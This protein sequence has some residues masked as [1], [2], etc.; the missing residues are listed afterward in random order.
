MNCRIEE[1]DTFGRKLH[2][3]IP[4]ADF[5]ERIDAKLRK[6]STTAEIKGFR[7]GKAPLE[8][9]KRYY[10]AEVKADVVNTLLYESYEEVTKQHDFFVLSNPSFEDIEIDTDKGIHYTA[11]IEVLP[12]LQLNTYEDITIEKPICEIT[13]KDID[14]MVERVRMN[15][16]TWQVK[17]GPACVGDKVTINV[18]IVETDKKPIKVFDDKSY[19]LGSKLMSERL[20]RQIENMRAGEKKE[21]SLR[22]K[23]DQKTVDTADSD[24]TAMRYEVSL[25]SV[26]TAVLPELD[27]DFFKACNIE[28]G[29]VDALRSSLREGMEWELKRK[30]SQLRRT[31]VENAMLTHANI[32]AP[33]AMMKE[34]IEKMKKILAKDGKNYVNEDISDE[35]FEKTAERKVC[36]DIL[37]IYI[38]EKNFFK[39]DRSAREAKINELVEGYKDPERMKNYYHG[40]VEAY[41]KVESMVLED[42]IIDYVIEKANISEKVYPFYE[43]MDMEKT[44]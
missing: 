22:E 19:I 16:A 35:L 39:I 12:D 6:L 14:T 30:L 10:G 31:N 9:I 28:E 15:H 8:I 26:A 43:L 41:R 33:P 36:L 38:N 34:Q 40:S 37:F 17:D 24:K 27:D 2:I 18:N 44:Q 13:E 1:I 3:D 42:K 29:G 25:K 11:Y 5:N 32:K 21:I 23:I 4:A 20:D 7:P